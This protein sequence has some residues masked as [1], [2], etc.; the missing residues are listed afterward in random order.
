MNDTK[1]NLVRHLELSSE[2]RARKAGQLPDDG[3]HARSAEALARAAK[4][5][6][7][8]SDADSRLSRI[9]CL[10]YSGDEEAIAAYDGESALIVAQHGFD[11]ADAT[12]DEL[13]DT[14]AEV[15]GK[16]SMGSSGIGFLPPKRRR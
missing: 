13:L 5:V 9:D 7:G 8:L 14:L 11:D 2:W 6:A 10:F 16:A 4:D 1:D 12:T 3:R 15:A